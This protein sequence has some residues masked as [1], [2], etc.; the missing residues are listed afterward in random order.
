[1]VT[2][3][4]ASGSRRTPAHY[5]EAGTWL[6]GLRDYWQITQTELAEMAGIPD[7][8]MIDWIET[9]EIRPPA[10]VFAAYARAFGMDRKEFTESCAMY[11]GDKGTAAAA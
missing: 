10:F 8:A 3:E 4:T 2:R 9:G 1:M 5:G 6:R 11:Y 7:P